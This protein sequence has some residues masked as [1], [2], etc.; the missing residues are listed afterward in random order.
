MPRPCAAETGDRLAEPEP[1]ELGG[2][3]RRR[4][5]SSILFAATTTGSAAAAQQVGDLLVAGAQPGPR[6]DHEHRDLGVGQRRARLV[7]DRDGE[8]VVVLEVDAAGVDQRERA[9]V[10]LGREL[11]AV[12]RDARALVHDRLARLREAVDQRGLADVRDSRRPRP[13]CTSGAPCAST[14]ERDDLARRPRR[15]S[16]PVVSTGDRV[17]R[18]ARAASARA[19]RS[20]SSRSACS[21][22]TIC[23]VG[24]ELGGAAAR[25]LRRRRRS[26]RP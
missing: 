7:L 21:A 2:E 1:V 18:G 24:A 9:P 8:R 3:R 20:R 23:G 22:S 19:V 5:A 10:P 4:S 13:S 12:A 17:G 15:A 14:R 6:V 26:G 11:L 25:A 16:R